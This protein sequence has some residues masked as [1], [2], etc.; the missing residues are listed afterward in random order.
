M[1]RDILLENLMFKGYVSSFLG[2]LTTQLIEK[3]HGTG[4]KLFES[5]FIEFRVIESTFEVERS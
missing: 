3:H 5:D 4:T 2:F 1:R